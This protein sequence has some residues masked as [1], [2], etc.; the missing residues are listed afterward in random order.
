MVGTKFE[1]PRPENEPTLSYLP[2]SKERAELKAKL[3]DMRSEQIEIPLVIAGEEVRTGDTKKAVMPHKHDHVLGEFHNAGKEEVHQ[4]IDAALDASESWAETPWYDRAAIFLKAADLLAGPYRSTI[5]AAAMLGLSKTVY[6][7]EIDGANELPDF[8]RFNAYF[9]QDIYRTQV[10]SGPQEWNRMEYRPLEGFVFA[11]TPFNF[12]SI[13]GNLPTAPALMGNVVIWKPASS[14]VYTSYHVMRVLIEAGL[15]PGVINFVPGPGSQVGNPILKHPDL[16]GIHF[17]GS[18]STFRFMWKQVGERIDEYKTFPRLVGETGG[19]DFVFVHSSADVPAVATALIRGAFQYQGQK[20]SAASR[21]YIPNSL[22]P[23]TKKKLLEDLELV[24]VGDP[25]NFRNFMNA[26]IDQDAFD[27]I[28]SYI[29]YARESESNE[30]IAGGEY[31]NEVGYFIDPTVVV[32]TDPK[33][34]L[35]REEIFG[36]VLTIYV[37]PDEEY[38]ETLHLCDK[39]SPYGL[40]GSIFAKNRDAIVLATDILRHAAGN[41]YINNKPTAAVVGRQP[42]GGARA[43][44]T[45]DKAGSRINLMRWVSPRSI[46]ENFNPAKFFVYNHMSEP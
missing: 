8:L 6:Q 36:P 25:E 28:T 34:K 4:A 7:A 43:S 20:C 11:V 18:T 14:A 39:T 27:N 38:K 41:F 44:G 15:P 10:T 32:T 23:Q 30:I 37:Y 17:T 29:E 3:K 12:V 5:N 46:K 2:E 26:V 19:K 45:N 35:M 13:M 42:F 40:T 21:A 22:W 24:Q 33:N 31:D 16:A 1:I 9:M